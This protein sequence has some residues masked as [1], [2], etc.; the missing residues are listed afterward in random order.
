LVG[1]YL[2]EQSF[3]RLRRVSDVDILEVGLRE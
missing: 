3:G 1:E 2:Q